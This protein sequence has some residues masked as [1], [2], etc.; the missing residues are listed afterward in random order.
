MRD[1]MDCEVSLAM[2][3]DVEESRCCN[4]ILLSVEQ[5]TGRSRGGRQQGVHYPCKYSFL[6]RDDDRDFCCVHVNYSGGHR[7]TNT[8][9]KP[10]LFVACV[11]QHQM[12]INI[13]SIYLTYYCTWG[14]ELHLWR[15]HV[16]KG[17]SFDHVTANPV[18]ICDTL[19]RPSYIN[20]VFMWKNKTKK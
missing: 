19:R 7:G 12:L 4:R 1:A 18:P 11:C 10:L 20:F 16:I 6:S 5:T 9:I 15:S 8:I 14:V 17:A 2:Y 13:L 3:R